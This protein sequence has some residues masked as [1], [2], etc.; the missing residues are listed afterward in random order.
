[1]IKEDIKVSVIVPIY[2][3][4]KY[5]TKCIETIMNQT[6]KNIEIILVDDGSPDSS[7]NICDEYAKKD[8]R[9]KVIHKDN[10]GVSAARNSGIDIATGDYVCFVDGDDY[11]MDDYVEYLLK[12]SRTGNSD[13]V[14]STELFSDYDLKQIKKDRIKVY[15]AEETTEAILCYKIPIGVYNKLFK[16]SFLGKDI[17]FLTELKIGE[18]FNFNTTAFQKANNVTVGHRKIYF[19][20][21][22]N[23]TSVTTKFSAE[24]WKNGLYALEVIKKNFII[25][26]KRLERAWEFANWR[27]HTDVY[28]LLV[29]ANAVSE[30]TELYKRCLSITRRQAY[31]SFLVPI[32]IKQR[33]R[34]IIIGIYPKLIPNLMLMRRKKY[35]VNVEN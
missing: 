15:T 25:K 22:D 31:L 12:L 2:N 7:G 33:L 18:G 19:Y 23:P 34:A 13:V 10:E 1:M 30:N 6:Y 21:K 20:R 26:T 14:L 3:V 27:T 5:L 4:E 11:V 8:N 24:K 29:L 17:R 35:N 9:I 32:S 28:D 16:R